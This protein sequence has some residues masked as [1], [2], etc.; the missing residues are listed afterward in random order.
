[1]NTRTEVKDKDSVD[2]VYLINAARNM[3]CGELS[4]LA[5]H[6]DERRADAI[7]SLTRAFRKPAMLR[8][9]LLDSRACSPAGG[10]PGHGAC[11]PVTVTGCNGFWPPLT[12]AVVRYCQP[13]DRYVSLPQ[14]WADA[15]P[16][17]P[18]LADLL[19]RFVRQL[20]HSMPCWSCAVM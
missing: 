14:Q 16:T 10:G 1:M 12:P 5:Q 6:Q 11:Y 18:T 2:R 9:A 19:D 7:S 8:F 13:A 20:R 4:T 3:P 17:L 15:M